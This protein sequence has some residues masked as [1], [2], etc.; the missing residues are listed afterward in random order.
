MAH[1]TFTDRAGRLWEVWEV[2]PTLT[3]RR[4]SSQ[5]VLV[6]RRRRDEPRV[7]LPRPLRAGWLAFRCKSER[8]RIVPPPDLWE[9]LSDAELLDLL[10]EAAPH[11]RPRRLLD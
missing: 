3:E 6:E 2:H 5:P 1:R 10:E 7:S 11:P 9:Q 4:I 8:R